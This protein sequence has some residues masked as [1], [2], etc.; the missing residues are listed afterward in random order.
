V[1]LC[2]CSYWILRRL[3]TPKILHCH[4]FPS[5]PTHV[6]DSFLK[7]KRILMTLRVVPSPLHPLPSLDF[8]LFWTPINF[9]VPKFQPCT[10]LDNDALDRSET[11][12]N[13]SKRHEDTY[14]MVLKAARFIFFK[15]DDPSSS[16]KR[17]VSLN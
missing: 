3:V 13:T 11:K 1:V 12:Q 7:P 5:F 4:N 16:P 10:K 17:H 15:I 6:T 14:S 9:N 2:W 8:I